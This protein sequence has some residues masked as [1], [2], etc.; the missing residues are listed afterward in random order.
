MKG[1]EREG[2]ERSREGI[3]LKSYNTLSLTGKLYR[4][5]GCELRRM[6]SHSE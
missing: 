3:V 5:I 6:R 1:K 2:K 4:S